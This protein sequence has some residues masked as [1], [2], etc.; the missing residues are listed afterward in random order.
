MTVAEGDASTVQPLV[1]PMGRTLFGLAR[2]PVVDGEFLAA[3][4]LGPNRWVTVRPLQDPILSRWQR[5]V[6]LWFVVS[7]AAV[8]PL[9]Y[10][11]SRRLAAPLAELAD[12]ADRLGRDASTPVRLAAGTPEVRRLATAF[13]GM[14]ARLQRHV[15]DRTAMVGAISHDLRTPL[16][17]LRFKLERAPPAL[18]SSMQRDLGQTEDMLDSV[19]LFIRDASE[20]DVREVADLRSIVECVVDDAALV[21]GDATLDPGEDAAVEVDILSVQRVVSNLVENALKYGGLARVRL[22]SMVGEAV[23]EVTDAGPGLPDVELEKVFQPFYRSEAGRQASAKGIGLG[24]SVSRSIARAHGGDITLRNTGVGLVAEL[25]LPLAVQQRHA[26][27][28]PDGATA[29]SPAA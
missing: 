11:F 7:F 29:F 23:L 22:L 18:K 21:G 17:R 25:R 12:T 6:A 3:L 27:R 20:P 5:R 15:D 8:A 1:P 28:A 24:L 19:L 14:Q 26:V 16:A 10:L 9:G 4:R 2:T 13:A